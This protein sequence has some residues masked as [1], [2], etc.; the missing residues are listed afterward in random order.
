MR[1][2]RA[3]SCGPCGIFRRGGAWSRSSSSS[4]SSRADESRIDA[5][6]GLIRVF[7]WVV[8][9]LGFIGTVI[10]IGAAVSG[11]STTL[12]STSSIAGMRESIESVTTGL[13]V[14]FDTTLLA[15]VMSILVMF[16]S[17]ALQRLEEAFLGEVDDYCAEHLVRRLAEEPEEAR[18]DAQLEQLVERLVVALRSRER[19]GG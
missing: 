3:A 4:P 17:T 10:G 7:I 5:S 15:L 18:S 9:T 2:S 16:P 8:P 11:F 12:E 1:F 13:G 6:Y 14:A 19:T